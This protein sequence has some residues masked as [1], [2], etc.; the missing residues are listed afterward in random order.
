MP[1]PF[2][3]DLGYLEKFLGALEAHATSLPEPEGARLASLLREE[4]ARWEEIGA[5]LGGQA[6]PGQEADSE[7]PPASASPARMAPAAPTQELPRPRWT[8]GSLLG[9]RS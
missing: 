8:V 5:L 1:A 6:A 7:A 3:R 2:A 4:R 9:D